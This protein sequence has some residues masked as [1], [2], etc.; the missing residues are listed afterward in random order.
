[1]VQ[2]HIG[3]NPQ[4]IHGN[5]TMAWTCVAWRLNLFQGLERAHRDAQTG[6]VWRRNGTGQVFARGSLEKHVLHTSSLES[7]RWAGLPQ[8]EHELSRIG[9][10]LVLHT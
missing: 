4:L 6:R 1:M 10:G 9:P 2:L 8:G 3:I 7:M 5:Y